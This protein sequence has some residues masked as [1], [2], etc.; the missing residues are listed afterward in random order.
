VHWSADG[1]SILIGTLSTVPV[2]IDRLT[3]ATG[4]RTPFVEL[5]PSDRSGALYTYEA[6]FSEDE[7][8][9]AYS[10]VRD[11]SYLYEV[12]PSPR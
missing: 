5:A 7:R 8:A 12:I 10:V 3:L 2:R 9:Y 6:A 11:R 4:A 1:R